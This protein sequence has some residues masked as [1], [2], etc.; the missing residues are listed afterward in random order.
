MTYKPK[1]VEV[2]VYWD[3]ENQPDYS[4]LGIE[5]EREIDSMVIDFNEI[6]RFNPSNKKEETTVGLPGG[7]YGIAMSFEDFNGLY[8]KIMEIRIETFDRVAWN[9][10]IGKRRYT[11]GL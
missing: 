2:P 7:S 10:P 3:K 9:A 1:M 4:E 5:P 11:D 8:Q 6:I